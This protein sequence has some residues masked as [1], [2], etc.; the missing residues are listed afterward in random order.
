MSYRY[1][2][3]QALINAVAGQIPAF[4]R[5]LVVK[6]PNDT[7]DYNYQVLQEVMEPLDGQVMFFTSISDAYD[8]AQTNNDDVI[9]LDAHTSHKV[10]AQLAISKNRIHFLGFDGGGRKIGSRAMI[11][12]TSTGAAT[13]YAMVYNYGT[14]NT[15][16]NI[17]FKNNW[18]VA[19]NVYS[20]KEWGIQSYYENC[21]FEAL[22]SA[23]LTNASAAS[24][25]LG[26][27]ECIFKNCIGI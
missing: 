3:R 19:Q 8:A 20:V 15:F 2:Y 24:L 14:G 22:G 1:N 23:H 10:T 13:D 5:I 17:S 16:R 11:S 12:N 6:N 21:D 26:G 7:A 9:C 25:N 4:G 27:N 18:T